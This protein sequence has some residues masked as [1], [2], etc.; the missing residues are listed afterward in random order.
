MKSDKEKVWDRLYRTPR[1]RVELAPGIYMRDLSEFGAE[2]KQ[3]EA[4]EV[5][6]KIS[7]TKEQR[8]QR[9]L[10]EAFEEIDRVSEE[11]EQ[12]K[13]YREADVSKFKTTI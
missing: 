12:L 2:A 10:T 4:E 1:K 13:L 5:W 3:Q 8:Y 9:E 6:Q 7:E 11:I